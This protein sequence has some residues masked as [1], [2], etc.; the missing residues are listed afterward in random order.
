MDEHRR[1]DTDGVDPVATHAGEHRP[2]DGAT[3]LTHADWFSGIGGF[4][5]A[6]ERAGFRTVSFSEI[7]PV[8]CRIL[9]RHWPDVP[10]IGDITKL[11]PGDDADDAGG[12]TGGR[13]GAAPDGGSQ[14]DLGGE[15]RSDAVPAD[16]QRA[17]VWTGG[18]PCQDVS[19]A[20]ARRGLVNEDGSLTR[21][22]LALTW[23]D[24][25]RQ[26]Q[27][28]WIIIENVPGLLSS[29]DGAD[30]ATIVGTLEQLG[31]GWAYRTLDAQY[32][33]VPQ[34]RRRVFIVAAL[35]DL[36]AVGPRAVLALTE[37]GTGDPDPGQPSWPVA[38]DR[39]ADGIGGA[40]ILGQ[41][42]NSKWHKG[43]SGPAGD[44]HHNLV[45]GTLREHVRPGSNTDHTVL[46][47]Q[48]SDSGGNGAPAGV[49]GRLDSP[50]YTVDGQAGNPLA[51]STNFVVGEVAATLNSGGN[52]GGF[53]T[54]P[55]EHLVVVDDVLPTLTAPNDRRTLVDGKRQDGGRRDKVPTV[56]FRKAGRAQ[57]S[58][59]V[60]SWTEGDVANTLN[61]FDDTGDA[62][63]TVA[64]L[65]QGCQHISE[66]TGGEWCYDCWSRAQIEALLPEGQDSARYKAVGNAICVPV[67]EWIARRLMR[68]VTT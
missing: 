67:V 51:H 48:A 57:T 19:M 3:G 12:T 41:A 40:G 24:L 63:A 14:P 9:E 50:A 52:D 28:P 2:I 30:M 18:F 39:F 43:S 68:L 31:Y 22:G 23:F 36:A 10:N 17:F 32:F 38:T 58:E 62:R 60:E 33:G 61:R 29:N 20:G 45:I 4:S 66:E 65:S 64:I 56:V 53:R 8:P 34:R 1:T 6:F 42:V 54:E 44:E 5:L 21:S 11:A 15:G 26:H 16:W 27:P 25:V 49:P 47:R 55:G 37:G 13:Q 46:Q 7:E 59:S 35:G